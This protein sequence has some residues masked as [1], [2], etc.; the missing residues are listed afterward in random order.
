LFVCFFLSCFF[1]FLSF[2]FSFFLF[3][4]LSFLF[5]FF[6]CCPSYVRVF[7]IKNLQLRV[8]YLN[9]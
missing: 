8:N 3:F 7:C 6:V 4:F 5:L 2:F 1:L 9:L